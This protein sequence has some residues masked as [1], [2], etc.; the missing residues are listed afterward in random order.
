MNLLNF[1]FD[2]NSTYFEHNLN[3]TNIPTVFI[4][5]VGLDNTMWEPQKKN[6]KTIK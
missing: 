4:H 1:G 3:A 6:F 5:G 2:S